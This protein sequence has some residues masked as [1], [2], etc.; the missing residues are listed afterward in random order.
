M[1]SID[2]R[3][4]RSFGRTKSR[5]INQN[6]KL[7]LEKRMETY[8]PDLEKL[9]NKVYLDIGFG[10]GES[11]IKLALDNPDVTII[12]CEAYVNGI[13]NLIREIE[14]HKI[15]NI[16]IFNGDAR[17]LLEQLKDSSIDKVFVLFPDPWPKKRH[18]KRRIITLPFLKLIYSKLK[19]KGTFLFASDITSYVEWTLEHIKK[20]KKFTISSLDLKDYQEQPKWW[21][22]TKYQQ[23]AIRE[24]RESYFVETTK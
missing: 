17:L 6:Q 18:H 16:R 5:N 8:S 22:L 1:F 7:E 20:S 14:K 23:K 12:A 15:T 4:I 3:K 21:V 11:T 9:S 24:G 2:K 10:Y 13:A 19:T